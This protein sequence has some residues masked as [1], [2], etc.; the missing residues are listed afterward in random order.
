MRRSDRGGA[1]TERLMFE[2]VMRAL[3]GAHTIVFPLNE[4][5]VRL[6]TLLR[7]YMGDG[8]N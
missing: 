6:F 4:Q 1:G 3:E 7:M 2:T 5:E 8:V